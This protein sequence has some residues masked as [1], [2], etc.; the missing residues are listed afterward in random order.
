LDGLRGL[1]AF[2]VVL[3]HSSLVWFSW[4]IHGGW[5]PNS[6]QTAWFVRLPIIRFFISGAPQV[7]IFFVVSG[8]AISH[9]PIKL[10]RQ[11][12]YAE[13]GATLSSS[14]FRRHSRL[15]LPAACITL[16][17]AL[18]IQLDPG[19]FGSEGLEGVAVPTRTVPHANNLLDQLWHFKD[20]EIQ[21]T[22][23]I[24][25]GLAQG[26][27]SRVYLNPY[28][29][30]LWTLPME[31]SSSFVVFLFL[32]A[33]ARIRNRVRMFF[34]LGVIVYFQ[35][36]FGYWALY[37]FLCG[38]LICDIHFEMDEIRAKYAA[39]PD[40]A[41]TSVLPIGVVFGLAA[42]LGSLWLLSTPDAFLGS[43]QSWG[44]VTL[45]SW[46]P[47]TLRDQA[48]VPTG[49]ALLVLVVDQ[50]PFL[51][52]L[53]TN[54]FAQYM[55]RISYA[56]YLVH[57][58][59][60]WSLGLSFAHTTLDLTGKEGD[61][62]YGFGIFLAACLWWPIAIYA[63]DLTARFVDENCVRLGRWVYEKLLKQES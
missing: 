28:D 9:K 46:V 57:G 3:H 30:N 55:G 54:S 7:R 59:L 61:W 40:S 51:Q 5:N 4:K 42:F 26:G 2:F 11:G 31:F 50:F 60:L 17:S 56:L 49:A 23:P 13:I 62:Q 39:G 21:A 32:T 24:S 44:F 8:Y 1:A 38:M 12:R 20:A 22:N 27:E 53:F 19:W 14:V 10:A 58:P 52:I 45:V 34:A 25:Q 16:L 43:K 35:Y 63:A 37:P 15:F 33:F 29:P 48:L 41:D 36:N 47:E 18:I 6:D